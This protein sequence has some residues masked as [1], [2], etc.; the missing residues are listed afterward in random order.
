[1]EWY[2]KAAEQGSAD[3]QCRVGLMYSPGYGVPQD[4]KVAM[5]WFLNAAEQRN[6]EA[7]NNIGMMYRAGNGATQDYSKTLE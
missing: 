2:F 4:L 6:L 3:G 5:E 7:M 1:M